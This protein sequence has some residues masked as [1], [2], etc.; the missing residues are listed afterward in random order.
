MTYQ[1]FRELFYRTLSSL[2]PLSEIRAQLHYYLRERFSIEAHNFYLYPNYELPFSSQNK[3]EIQRLGRGEPLQYVLGYT[4]FSDLKLKVSPDVLIPRPET[5]ELVKYVLDD[6]LLHHLQE[7]PNI[8]DIGTGSGAIAI[9]LATQLPSASIVAIDNS[10][11]VLA[12]AKENGKL[13][14]TKIFFQLW[15]IL[16]MPVPHKWL[17]K[18][19]YI[20]SNPPYIPENEKGTLHVNVR[21]FEPHGALFVSDENPLSFYQ[22]IA[23]MGKKI[24]KDGG[25]I[26]FETHENY[27][28]ELE[29]FLQNND[30]QDIIKIKDFQNK[31]RIIFCKKK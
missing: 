31:P 23:I 18:F 15:D 3:E 14:H 28:K 8:I 25:K 4:Y 19:D 7:K 9:A 30:Y 12:V 22:K 6:C 29:V 5:E 17:R 13:H 10:K 16:K 11:Q 24:L 27:Q 20:V 21:T 26:F 2:Y 1:Q